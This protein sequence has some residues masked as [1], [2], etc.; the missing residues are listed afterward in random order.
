MRTLICSA[1]ILSAS[2]RLLALSL[3]YPLLVA[4]QPRA[5][6]PNPLALVA[7]GGVHAMTGCTLG[8][9]VSAVIHTTIPGFRN[10]KH[11][12][13]ATAGYTATIPSNAESDGGL[14]VVY[15]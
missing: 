6:Q 1:A 12:R 7:S 4:T 15:L 3:E 8:K 9:L 10:A 5:Q 11:V 2:A 13:C 14:L